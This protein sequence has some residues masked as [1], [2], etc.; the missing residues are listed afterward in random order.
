MFFQKDLKRIELINTPESYLLNHAQNKAN[1]DLLIK[2][3]DK[4]KSVSFIGAGVSKSLGIQDW[5]G[6]ID[7]LHKLLQLYE[8]KDSKPDMKC[9]YPNFAEKIFETLKKRNNEYLFFE[10]I[11][12]KMNPTINSTSLTLIYLSLA[13][14]IHLT[15]N[16][17]RSIESAFNAVGHLSE[18]FSDNN[19]YCK[20]S[21]YYLGGLDV[22]SNGPSVYYLHGS[23]DKNTYILK[24]TDYETFIQ[25]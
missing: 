5:D 21:L 7:D 4:T 3:Y 14:D 6:L 1:Y 25:V 12:E 9:D 11:A 18:M 16:F 10:T 2:T 23:I 19:D 15:T 13:I 24:K 20:P 17:D 22:N 8:F